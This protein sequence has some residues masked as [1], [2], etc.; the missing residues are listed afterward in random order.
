MEKEWISQGKAL[1]E[2]A[3]NWLL[4]VGLSTKK[5]NLGP[6]WA[7]EYLFELLLPVECIYGLL[8][9]ALCLRT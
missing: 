2:V 3:T 4:Y 8:L 9:L 7:A 1:I 6:C 5:K